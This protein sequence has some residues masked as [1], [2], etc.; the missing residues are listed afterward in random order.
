MGHLLD[1]GMVEK[2]SDSEYRL[3][4]SGKLIAKLVGERNKIDNKLE[5]QE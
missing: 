1:D 3:T 4:D 2:N 5:N